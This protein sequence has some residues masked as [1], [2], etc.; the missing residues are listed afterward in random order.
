MI[1]KKFLA[2]I[3]ALLSFVPLFAHADITSNLVGWWQF[4]EGSG[5]SASDSSGNGNTGTLVNSPTWVAGQ[6]N[7]ALQFNG[8]SQYVSIPNSTSL[9]SPATNDSISVSVWLKLSSNN[10]SFR[11]IVR[12]ANGST[13]WFL[14]VNTSN[15][16]AFSTSA[17]SGEYTGGYADSADNLWHLVTA[18]FDGTTINLYQ[19]GVL[20]TSYAGGAVSSDSDPIGIASLGN[21]SAQFLGAAI[22]D[23]R[24]YSRALSA[25]DVAQLYQYQAFGGSAAE[26]RSSN[27]GIQFDSINNG[28]N[29]SSSPNYQIQDTAGETATGF[30]TSTNYSISAGY[31]QMQTVA[32]SLVPPASVVM[33]PAFGGVSGGTG[34]GSTTMVVTTDD[35][36]G[37]Y[38]TIQASSSPALVNTA[39]STATFADY[40]PAGSNPDFAFS[41]SS[42][43]ASAFAFSVQGNDADQRFRN[44]SS[45]CNAG[46]SS[47]AQACW[48][49]LST[50]PKTIAD[51]TTDNQ[52]AGT[53][54]TLWFR[55]S[56]GSSHIQPSGLYVATTTITVVPL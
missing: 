1:M 14:V 56:S 25:T 24:V 22:D 19:D 47:T 44:N 2:T 35:A 39:S 23:V 41:L 17:A 5:S 21:G 42:P 45:A 48:D 7:D 36:A 40:V 52:P 12:K 34:N 30:S 13:G 20:Q 3:I 28:G 27:Y 29:Y 32:L 33:S 55:A 53:P 31:Q 46:S 50:S 4:D 38:A 37:Y 8:T 9:A 43:S 51:R 54:T 16:I 6:I 10:S 11:E 18:T 15:K 26:M 49:G